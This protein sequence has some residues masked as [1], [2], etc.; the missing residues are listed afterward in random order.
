MKTQTRLALAF[1]LGLCAPL[2][3]A[4]C[5]SEEDKA[6]DD[7]KEAVEGAADAAKEAAGD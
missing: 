6:A 3:F 5:G 7:A 2:A 4:S 1:F